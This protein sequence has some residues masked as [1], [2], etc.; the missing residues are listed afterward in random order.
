ML[1][2]DKIKKSL[3]NYFVTLIKLIK[4]L[5]LVDVK[6]RIKKIFVTIRVI[7]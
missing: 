2:F 7:K 4:I 5:L 3:K 6:K 1:I